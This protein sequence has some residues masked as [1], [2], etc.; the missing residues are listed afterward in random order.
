MCAVLIAPLASILVRLVLSR[1]TCALPAAPARTLL[2]L[3]LLTWKL[4]PTAPLTPTPTLLVPLA[5]LR[6]PLASSTPMQVFIVYPRSL[7]SCAWL[8]RFYTLYLV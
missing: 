7:G 2:V 8:S 5:V 4:A 6:A 1:A 3:V